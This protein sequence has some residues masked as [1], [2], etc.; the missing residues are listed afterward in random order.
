MRTSIY[1]SIF[2]FSLLLGGLGCEGCEESSSSTSGLEQRG[3]V[4]NAPNN[5]KRPVV[6]GVEVIHAPRQPESQAPNHTNL[7]REPNAPDPHGGVFTLEE[8]VEGMPTDGQLVAEFNTTFGTFF[9]DLYADKV[10]NTVANFIGLARGKRAWW[11]ARAGEWRLAPAYERTQIFKVVPDYM[12]QGGDYLNDGT[13]TVGYTI[14]D[15]PHSDLAH[16]EAGLLCMASSGENQNGAQW[17]VTDGPAPQLD[18]DDQFTIFG[19]CAQVD[20]IERMARVPQVEDNRPVTPILVTRVRIRRV[21]GGA[22]VAR[23]TPPRMPEGV[24]PQTIGREASPGPSEI[25]LPARGRDG[26][27]FD[28]RNWT[29]MRQTG[30]APT[31]ME[32]Q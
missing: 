19:R 15:E 30:M 1:T 25:N 32:G 13:G 24:D 29:G 21:A 23:A 5:T 2:S 28:P 7:I 22:A 16:D 31:E 18:E 26:Q 4:A 20:T 6:N 11:D 8:A 9:C 3:S 17:F 12:V 27:V 14:D 10:P